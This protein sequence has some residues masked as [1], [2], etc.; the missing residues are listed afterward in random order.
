MPRC[1]PRH[2]SVTT[3]LCKADFLVVIDTFLLCDQA[4][5]PVGGIPERVFIRGVTRYVRVP[6]G[7][8]MLPCCLIVAARR[9][10]HEVGWY[11]FC[12]FL[13][14]PL[15]V[16]LSARKSRVSVKCKSERL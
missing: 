11:S 1:W 13:R 16:I 9:H 2:M 10:S 12:F 5:R 14:H 15:Q 4:Q 6:I 3:L 7:R 8:C